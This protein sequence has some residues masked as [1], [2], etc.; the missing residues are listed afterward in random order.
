MPRHPLVSIVVP[1][2]NAE[3]YIDEAL[4]SVLGQTYLNIE[5][6]VVNDGSTD[7]TGERVAAYHPKAQCY[8][9][10][11]SGGYP[12]APRNTGMRHCGGEFICFL[13][14]DDVMPTDRVER[15]VEFLS[16]HPDVGVV[17]TDYQNFSV[18]G[19]FDKTHFETCSR[20]RERLGC[21]AELVLQSKEA[22]HLLLHETFGL[23]SSMMIRRE[24]LGV[25]PSFSTEFQIGEDFHYY[26]RIARHYSVGVVNQVGAYRRLHD[27]NITNNGI[28]V[29]HNTALMRAQLRETESDAESLRLLDDHLFQ[30][31]IH[32]A[33]AYANQRELSKALAHNLRAV[34]ALRM[35]HL[36]HI[37][38]G[39]RAFLRT[40]AIALHIK[41]PSP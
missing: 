32:L 41:E 23:P 38:V 17:F 27:S 26:Y 25:V 31:E 40:V 12:G 7:A 20:L 3:R 13:D 15:Q 29:L 4:R 24:V 16:K 36:E 39:V 37:K 2:Y 21:E 1:A 10:A 19:L 22:T 9:Q 11:N 33:R 35:S 14:A 8:T 28:R 6:I 5:V 34:A 18:K 30:S